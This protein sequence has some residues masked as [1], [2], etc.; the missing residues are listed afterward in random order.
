MPGVRV[1]VRQY[2]RFPKLPAILRSITLRLAEHL[3]V[4][5]CQESVLVELPN[6]VVWLTTRAETGTETAS[7][8][9]A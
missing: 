6:E 1:G 4:V 8:T 2:P 9:P 7:S 3:R 5:M